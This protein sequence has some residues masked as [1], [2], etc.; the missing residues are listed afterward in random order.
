MIV[1]VALRPAG[2]A[3]D[4]IA[5]NPSSPAR[6]V[7]QPGNLTNTRPDITAASRGD[8]YRCIAGVRDARLIESDLTTG[9][10]TKSIVTPMRSEACVRRPTE[11]EGSGDEVIEDVGS[12][13]VPVVRGVWPFETG[14]RGVG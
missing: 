12:Q 3:D 1:S 13:S 8:S 4:R 6:C 5:L 9:M 10:P 2:A 11:A 7:P 14:R